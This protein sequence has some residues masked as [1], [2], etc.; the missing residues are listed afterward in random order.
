MD[1]TTVGEEIARIGDPEMAACLLADVGIYLGG[2]CQV[3]WGEFG[4]CRHSVQAF[5]LV[6]PDARRKGVASELLQTTVERLQNHPAVEKVTLQ[7][8]D[9]DAALK[10]LLHDKGWRL[11][12][13]AIGALRTRRAPVD[14]LHYALDVTSPPPASR[15]G[16][17]E[18]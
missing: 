2:V 11:E 13:R 1:P 3:L 7:V 9:C 15:Q 14:V 17:R 6:H 18:T 5:I 16:E 10:Q 12:R 4:R 8:A